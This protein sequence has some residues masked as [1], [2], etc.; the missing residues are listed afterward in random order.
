MRYLFN[1]KI[2]KLFFSKYFNIP[3][4]A[5]IVQIGKNSIHFTTDG[6]TYKCRTF[7]TNF[8][9][10]PVLK[11]IQ[12]AVMLPFALLSKGFAFLLLT[13]NTATNNKD[14]GISQYTPT[15]NY[16][17][18]AGVGYVA[19]QT[20]GDDWRFLLHFT[21]PAGSGTIS[22]VT[23]NLYQYVSV[24]TNTALNLEVHELSR[25][26]WTEAGVTWNKYD[27]TNNWTTAGGDFSAT[28]VHAIAHTNGAVNAYRTWQLGTG[29]TNPI[30]GLTWGGDVH[31]IVRFS[32]TGNNPGQYENFYPKENGSNTP[33]IEITYTAGSSTNSN[34]FAFM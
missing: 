4:E 6:V 19:S 24:G 26:N 15:T 16:G 20:G 10:H 3:T 25:T 32:N 18:N 21:L 12:A 28:I 29:A 23:L 5:T 33:Y 2:A 14:A 1:T 27:G 8:L 22:A 17:S 7:Q 9:D 30:S 11:R 31:L 34:F 13:D